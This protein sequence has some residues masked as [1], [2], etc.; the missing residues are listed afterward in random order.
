MPSTPQPAMLWQHFSFCLNTVTKG[1]I[2]LPLSGY[3]GQGPRGGGLVNASV[4]SR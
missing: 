4:P 1:Q 2:S 3:V